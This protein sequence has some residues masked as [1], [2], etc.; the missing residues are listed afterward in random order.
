MSQVPRRTLSLQQRLPCFPVFGVVSLWLCYSP[1]QAVFRCPRPTVELRVMWQVLAAACCH[2]PAKAL[3]Q[4]RV[5]NTLRSWGESERGAVCER[6]ENV[7]IWAANLEG[8][9]R[10]T[11]ITSTFGVVLLDLWPMAEGVRCAVIK[12]KLGLCGKLG[13]MGLFHRASV[14]HW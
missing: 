8:H 5:T 1:S 2:N 3:F 7:E 12:L 11:G 14:P 6:R 10:L 13:V 9:L 4:L